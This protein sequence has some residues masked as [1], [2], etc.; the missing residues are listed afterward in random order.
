MEEVKKAASSALIKGGLAILSDSAL[1]KRLMLEGLES[2]SRAYR[3]LALA[4]DN[5]LLLPFAEALEGDA[6][7][8][9]N[10]ASK[11][12]ERHLTETYVMDPSV[13]EE[14]SDGIAAACAD[15]CSLPYE[16]IISYKAPGKAVASGP[17]NALGPVKVVGI[18]TL[19]VCAFALAGFLVF[20]HFVPVF[21]CTFIP[22][23]E[24]VNGVECSVYVTRSIESG[25][26]SRVIFMKNCN[27]GPVSIGIN[28]ASIRSQL[29][30][31]IYL[32]TGDSGLFF[33]GKGNGAYGVAAAECSTNSV[34]Q[35][36]RNELSKYLSWR[37]GT[38]NDGG[39]AIEIV[40]SSTAPIS[41][42]VNG[43]LALA[44]HGPF[45]SIKCCNLTEN[46][47]PGTS[48]YE[49][50]LF[51]DYLYVGGPLKVSDS[52]ELFVNGVLIPHA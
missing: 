21:G 20:A 6:G 7:L 17:R 25:D 50:S 51:W 34:F 22:H 29:T 9:L 14:L 44:S 30:R 32:D 2:S 42:G 35:S 45:A 31:P 3:A 27:A 8:S 37:C 36:H 48:I 11:R 49:A 38:N 18:S 41:I 23:A 15:F 19:V 13:A 16:R 47:E 12:A 4:C 28:G 33:I 5:Q 1:F 26:L 46:I 43:I 39:L 52:A 10:E 24:T 40:N